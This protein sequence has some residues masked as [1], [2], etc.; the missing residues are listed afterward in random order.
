MTT[1]SLVFIAALLFSTAISAQNEHPNIVV[2]LA[3][4]FGVGDIQAH[5]PDNKIAT[6]YL[7]K[8]SS[9]SKRFTNAHAN[10][11]CCT[12]S[13]YGL[14]TGRYAWRTRLQEWVLACY[15]P[16]LISTDRL[17]LPGFLQQQ[18]YDTACI[19]KWHLG[20]NWAG[21]QPSHMTEQ[22][23][24]L[25]QLNWDFTQPIEDGPITRGFDYYFG[26]HVPTFAPF[27]F[28]ENDRVV[29]Q[30]TEKYEYDPNEGT[31]MPQ[32]FAG[33]PIAPG[34]KFDEI[35]PEITNRAVDYIH[36][37]A[38]N[39]EPFFLFFSMTS[40]HEPVVPSKRFK[41]KSGINDIAD[42]VMETDWSAG[43]VIEAVDK[44]GI[45]EDT[46]VIFTADNGHSHY[47]GLQE[48]LDAG[49]KPS[50]EFRG[51]KSNVW[52]GG[53]RVPYL[54]R[55]PGKVDA[56]SENHQILS[57]NDTFALCADILRKRLPAD[58][59][60][61][62]LSFLPQ[63]LGKKKKPTR[64]YVVSQST[65]GEF[66]Y[67]EGPWKIVYLNQG[68]TLSEARG[69]PTIVELYNLDRDV[70]ETTNVAKDNPEIVQ[71]LTRNLD[72]VIS[73]GTSRKG[74]PQSNDTLVD[75]KRTQTERWGPAL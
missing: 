48:L 52:E 13:R 23:N 7:D 51:H 18:G 3:D 60:E 67:Q 74:R 38:K 70:A 71:R 26:T 29:V 53:H 44:T 57:L 10:T 50:G 33:S 54:V 11:A 42:F 62:S 65:G 55:W 32:G 36:Q 6:P 31:V 9:E 41:G 37:N 40:P 19:G 58:A 49:H 63:L 24:G 4:D 5:Y 27:T 17:T 34:W 14:L 69:Q 2:I 45:A 8:F 16:P 61:D 66:G 22:R 72:K 75:F 59:A 28:I 30:P 46:I 56:G 25:M 47:T 68:G 43:K 12:P 73:R 1:K 15:E 20:W 35:L 64:N 21:D 39:E